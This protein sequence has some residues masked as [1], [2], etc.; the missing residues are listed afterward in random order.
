ME[1]PTLTN[2]QSLECEGIIS[3]TELPKALKSM[4]NDKSPGNDGITKE[5]CEFFGMTLKIQYLI[6]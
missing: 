5:F 6:Q 4:K 2:E 3:E 1:L